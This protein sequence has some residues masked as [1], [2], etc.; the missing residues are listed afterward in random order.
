MV[1]EQVVRRSDAALV[2][3]RRG[4]SLRE[5]V[6]GA[7]ARFLPG[8]LLTMV[9]G[10]SLLGVGIFSGLFTGIGGVIGVAGALTIG[11]GAGLLGLR[12]WL[13]PDARL[14][15]SRSFIAGLLS[16]LA[17]F[18][19]AALSRGWT[20]PQIPLVLGLVGVV[21]AVGMFFAWLTPTPEHM[22][23]DG[24]EPEAARVLQGE[25]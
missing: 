16:P 5:V 7:L 23:G 10:P 4:V 18:I 6:K 15:G 12:R 11:F 8:S 1:G 2:P 25:Q 19:V 3:Y 17:L 14:G 20:G 9:A 13:Y 24:F 22:R 21:M